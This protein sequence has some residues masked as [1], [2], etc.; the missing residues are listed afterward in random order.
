MKR[1]YSLF[2]TKLLMAFL[3]CTLIPLS[4]LSYVSYSVSRSIAWNK[5]MDAS[6]LQQTNSTYN[7]PR[8]SI[9][10]KM[11]QIHFNIICTPCLRTNTWIFLL[12]LMLLLYCAL[13]FHYIFPLLI[14][15]KSVYFC[16]M[17]IS[18]AKKVSIFIP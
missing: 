10:Q 8:E 15:T 9:R 5:T 6:S 12:I 3:L 2:Q 13:I 1:Y 18:E 16:T 7:S 11:L 17:T 14:F 4:I